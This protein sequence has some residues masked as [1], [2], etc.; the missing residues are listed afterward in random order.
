MREFDD[1][2]CFLDDTRTGSPSGCRSEQ[3]K[4]ILYFTLKRV[5]FRLHFVTGIDLLLTFTAQV[6]FRVAGLLEWC[7]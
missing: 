6:R 1:L 2:I 3:G 7:L 4:V 5:C